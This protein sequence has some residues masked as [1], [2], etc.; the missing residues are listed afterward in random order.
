MK[1]TLKNALVLIG[2]TPNI[3][4]PNKSQIHHF[5]GREPPQFDH[6]DPTPTTFFYSETPPKKQGWPRIACYG[7]KSLHNYRFTSVNY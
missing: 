2:V 7:L 3:H 6:I 1:E 5:K 4:M